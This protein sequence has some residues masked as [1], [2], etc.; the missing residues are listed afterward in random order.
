MV[1]RRNPRPPPRRKRK[2]PA[3][4][5]KLTKLIKNTQ[6]RVCETKKANRQYQN[7]AL[8]HNATHYS[9][10]YL[11]T[12][13][14]LEDP[15]G[16][17]QTI[18]NRIGDEIY[19]TGLQ[20]KFMFLTEVGRPNLNVRVYIFKYRSETFLTDAD[21]WC[22]TDGQGG[23]MPRFIDYPNKEKVQILKSFTVTHAPNNSNVSGGKQLTMKNCWINLKNMKVKYD[24][25]DGQYPK[26]KDIGVAVVCYDSNS[27]SY[28]TQIGEYNYSA[29]LF[30]K[31]P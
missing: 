18:D 14:G 29:R 30:F 16:M 9:N 10:N 5:N 1:F 25:D 19:A 22:G 13:Q 27:T 23:L 17:N 8:K 24:S 26:W 7:I 3:N 21:F 31:D 15:E 4:V 11:R 6:L 2:A 28:N 20:M 12:R